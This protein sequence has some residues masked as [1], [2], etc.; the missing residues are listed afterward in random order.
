MPA[1]PPAPPIHRGS[2]RYPRHPR[3][4]RGRRPAWRWAARRRR[5]L[6]L[7]L[8]TTQTLFA[9]YYMTAVLPYHGSTLVE[10][11]LLAA[12]ALSFAWVS[13]GAWLA[14]YGFFY[15]RLGGDPR[16]LDKHSPADRDYRPQTRTALIMPLYHEP[17]ETCFAAL[18]AVYRSLQASGR[19]AHF[20]FFVL[21]DSRDPDVWLE[22][23]AAWRHWVEALGAQGRLHYR[24][25]RVNLRHKSGNVADFLRRWGR[26]YD[27]FVVLDA[28]SLMDAETL[29]RMVQ[30][31]DDNPR[32]GI[33]QAPPRIVCAR[34]LFARIQQ[35]ANRL[36]GLLFSTGLAA[37]QLGDGAYWGHNAIIRT[38]AFMRHCGLPS[39]RGIGLF[40]G[41]ILSHDFVEAAYMR[42]GGYEV[43]L[44]PMLAGSYE[45]SPPT[46]V[47]ELTRDRRW[48][49]GNIQHLPV[50]IKERGLGLVQR[51]IFLNGIVAYAAAPLWLAFLVLSGIEV[52][53][54]TLWPINYFP[55]GHRLFPVWPEWHPQWAVQLAA[56]TAFVLFVPKLLSALDALLQTGLRRGF[57]G[58]WR[59]LAS[60]L[61]ESLA[62]VLL[63]PVR[64]L[65]HSRF[66]LEAIVGLRI[67]WGGQNRGGEIGWWPALLMHGDG[68]LLGIGWGI[69]SW[70]L[71]PLY[72][73]WSLPVIGPLVFAPV[74]AVVTSWVRSGDWC[75]RHGLL[76]TPEDREPPP[77][78]ADFAR[79]APAGKPSAP[80]GLAKTI[81]DPGRLAIARTLARRNGRCDPQMLARARSKGLEAL[82][83]GERLALAEDGDA[84]AELHA[85]GI[86]QRRA[87][88][89]PQ[90]Q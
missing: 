34:S 90:K 78:I 47:D 69:F 67:T 46:L 59:L 57:G 13:V 20:D 55:G 21:S 50:M 71:R 52:A 10:L 68:L 8:L 39:L 33:L 4:Q 19:I 37:L 86:A 42:R 72:F 15:R 79:L 43:W 70:W 60:V 49:R 44:E 62:S 89:S 28:D 82:S 63:A 1:T 26:D 75:A 12:F 32:V 14:V 87:P 81:G 23:Q 6:F 16:G 74:V 7:A 53:R 29:V 2:L 88:I 85:A 76:L 40:R 31:M 77:L 56:S 66:V 54:F 51:F 83:A 22:E 65:A 41:P 38:R 9:T 18:A 27:Y 11:A 48:A 24:R 64:M 25:R 58:G 3:R 35:F 80:R 61:I 45:Q 36:Y 73:Y 17:V 5:L 30:V 84:L